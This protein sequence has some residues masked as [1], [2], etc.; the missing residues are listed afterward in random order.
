LEAFDYVPP[1][2]EDIIK[3]RCLIQ[4]VTKDHKLLKKFR[5]FHGNQVEASWE[6]KECVGLSDEEAVKEVMK[7]L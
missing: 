7:R 4:Y 2:V 1:P 6:C 5:N 3:G